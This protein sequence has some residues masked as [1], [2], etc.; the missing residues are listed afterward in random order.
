M[1][2]SFN[3]KKSMAVLL[4]AFSL[5]QAKEPAKD[6]AVKLVKNAVEQL[7]KDPAGVIGR[8]NQKDPEFMVKE[9]ENLYVFVYDEDLVMLA[10][11]LKPLNVGKSWKGKKD[12]SGVAFRDSIQIKA[13]SAGS[14]WQEYI[15]Q[16]PTDDGLQIAKKTTYF[17]IVNAPDKKY[18]VCAGVYAQ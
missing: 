5:L 16:K 1:S 17:E 7:K 18:I 12:A 4:L 2:G 6:D 14:G 11:P 13:L 10:H 8:I 3:V 15:Y 9:L